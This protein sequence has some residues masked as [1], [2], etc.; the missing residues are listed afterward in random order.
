MDPLHAF[1][2]AVGA[3]PQLYGPLAL[4]ALL[5]ILLKARIEKWTGRSSSVL[6][7]VAAVALTLQAFKDGGLDVYSAPLRLLINFSLTMGAE[8]AGEKFLAEKLGILPKPNQ[9]VP[10]TPPIPPKEEA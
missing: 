4:V 2:E 5:N 1:L 7:A 9:L 8:F 6:A 10:P 3:D